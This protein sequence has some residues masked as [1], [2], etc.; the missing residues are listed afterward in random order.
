MKLIRDLWMIVIGLCHMIAGDIRDW[1]K[2][3]F[4]QSVTELREMMERQAHPEPRGQP[5][6]RQVTRSGLR[7]PVSGIY[8]SEVESN[9]NDPM[10]R[11]HQQ[12][13]LKALNNN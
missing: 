6:P 7:C 4:G 12:I 3:R 1:R 13:V 8:L 2:K 11:R 5:K 10:V 9:L